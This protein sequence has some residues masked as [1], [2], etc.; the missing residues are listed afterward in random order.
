MTGLMRAGT[1]QPPG[2][3]NPIKLSTCPKTTKK[4]QAHESLK[5]A[6][7]PPLLALNLSDTFDVA[8]K[9]GCDPFK[10]EGRPEGIQFGYMFFGKKLLKH[11]YRVATKRSCSIPVRGLLAKKC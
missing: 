4:Q 2:S 7:A 6:L 1:P 10:G 8:N 11:V 5:N 9:S 3:K